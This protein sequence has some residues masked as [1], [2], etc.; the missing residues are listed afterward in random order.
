MSR[1]RSL[2]DFMTAGVDAMVECKGCGRRVRAD[3]RALFA[4]IGVHWRKSLDHEGSKLRCTICG[5]R[6]ARLAPIP[7]IECTIDWQSL[8]A[9]IE[10]MWER[11]MAEEPPFVIEGPNKDGYVWICSSKG[12][13]VWCHNLGSEEQA[14]EVFSQWLGS[15]DYQENEAA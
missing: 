3:P 12:R 10:R 6:G 15:I 9:D 11:V 7:K 8:Q 13:D 5:H 2:Q 14:A 1:L 4:G